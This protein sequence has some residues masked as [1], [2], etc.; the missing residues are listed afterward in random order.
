MGIRQEEESEA[1]RAIQEGGCKKQ[2]GQGRKGE[3][4]DR[5]LR[6]DLEDTDN[7]RVFSELPC[8]PFPPPSFLP[9]LQ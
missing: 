7:G 2:P 4:S 9:N 3:P 6:E 5:Q 8:L 1:P